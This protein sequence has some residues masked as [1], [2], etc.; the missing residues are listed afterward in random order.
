MRRGVHAQA[1]GQ[2]RQQCYDTGQHRGKP[3]AGNGQQQRGTPAALPQVVVWQHA[4]PA[5]PTMLR[6]HA[7][8]AQLLQHAGC[9]SG[10]ATPAAALGLQRVCC[11]RR[12]EAAHSP[13]ACVPRVWGKVEQCSAVQRSAC[14]PAH[15]A[16]CRGANQPCAPRA[17]SRNA[18]ASPVPIA[19]AAVAGSLWMRTPTDTRTG[20]M[21]RSRASCAAARRRERRRRAQQSSASA[22]VRRV[23]TRSGGLHRRRLHTMSGCCCSCQQRLQH[24]LTSGCRSTQQRL[25]PAAL[26]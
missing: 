4:A 8:R 12:R 15:S 3:A 17:T 13:S 7:P 18:W 1:P 22:V 10:G 2:R 25:Q 14:R 20:R 21:R 23:S 6:W 19:L 11:W 26:P 5:R 9:G 16:D 24:P